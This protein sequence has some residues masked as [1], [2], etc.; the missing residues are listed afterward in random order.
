[1]SRFAERAAAGID[2]VTTAE[3]AAVGAFQA[4][5]FGPESPQADAARTRW[6]F[7]EGR[8]GGAGALNLWVC[9]RDGTVVGQQGGIPFDLAVAGTIRPAAWAV[10][11]MVDEAWRLRGVGPALSAAQW[12]GHD[13]VAGI[14]IGDAA[15]R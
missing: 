5:M 13:V 2:R 14:G 8:G 7:G 4:R 1:M 10:D 12:A 6:L 3:L 11:L 9:R 15:R